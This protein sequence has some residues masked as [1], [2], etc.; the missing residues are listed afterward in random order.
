MRRG[1][2]ETD[3]V[4]LKNPGSVSSTLFPS[5]PSRGDRLCLR[6]LRVWRGLVPNH[7]QQNGKEECGV[8][9]R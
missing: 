4:L 6:R 1:R 5:G 7:L 2:L 8:Q 9:H 3:D